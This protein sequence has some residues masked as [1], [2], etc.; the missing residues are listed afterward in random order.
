MISCCFPKDKRRGITVNGGAPSVLKRV[1]LGTPESAR[2][3][4]RA[5]LRALVWAGVNRGAAVFTDPVVARLVS[6]DVEAWSNLVP[7]PAAFENPGR[8][9]FDCHS[10]RDRC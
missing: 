8:R 7:C 5:R 4:D 10:L 2:E 9:R 6:V 3:C 1:V